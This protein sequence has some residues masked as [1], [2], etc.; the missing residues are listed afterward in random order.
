M[1]LGT[2]KDHNI[3]RPMHSKMFEGVMAL[4]S[5][6]AESLKGWSINCVAV[7]V[8]NFSNRQV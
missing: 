6:T 3:T 2:R 1:K 5:V 4:E 7:V 8:H